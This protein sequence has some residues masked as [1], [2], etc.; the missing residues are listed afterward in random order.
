[1]TNSKFNQF[2]V[3]KKGIG[4]IHINNET[5]QTSKNLSPCKKVYYIIRVL[6]YYYVFLLYPNINI[7]KFP[8]MLIFAKKI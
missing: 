3:N 8:K 2:S 1:M 5:Y 4:K 6:L 7:T